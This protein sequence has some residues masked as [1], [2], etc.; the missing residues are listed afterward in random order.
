[1]DTLVQCVGLAC[2]INWIN[3]SSE[4]DKRVQFR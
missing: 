3:V 2:P 1:M 4:L